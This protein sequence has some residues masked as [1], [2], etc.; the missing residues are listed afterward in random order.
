MLNLENGLLNE[1]P[2]EAIDGL[3]AVVPPGI[4]RAEFLEVS[5]G[6]WAK[7]PVFV[8]NL[9]PGADVIS[10]Q[11]SVH[12]DPVVLRADT[13]MFSTGSVVDNLWRIVANEISPGSLNVALAGPTPILGN[14]V[15]VDLHF[16]VVG[17]PGDSTVL[18]LENGLLN[19]D[20]VETV[21]GLVKV[22]A[23]VVLV[24]PDNIE[25]NEGEMELV[26]V[27]LEGNPGG[28]IFSAEMGIAYNPAVVRA[29][30]VTLAG[31][32]V[33]DSPSL[34]FNVEN[35]VINIG[36]ASA[37]PI[38]GDGPLVFIKF[39]AVGSDGD[40]TDVFIR[41]TR[42]GR[43]P[44][45][46]EG[47]IPA[48]R[49]G[50]IRIIEPSVPSLALSDT[51]LG[52]GS[53]RIDSSSQRTL[54]IINERGTD[55][56]VDSLFV[57]NTGEFTIIEPAIEPAPLDTILA[58]DSL[59]VTI[60]FKPWFTGL[61]EDTLHILS[62]D[63]VHPDTTVLLK[64][65]TQPPASI[66]DI[67]VC[68][69]TATGATIT[70][71]TDRPATLTDSVRVLNP[72]IS[73]NV[74]FT[75][76]RIGFNTHLVGLS[77]L[78]PDVTGYLFE[79]ISEGA[80]S[81]GEFDTP[82]EG[83]PG[84]PQNATVK[85]LNEDGTDAVGVLV[86]AT[87]TDLLSSIVSLPICG[88]TGPTGGATLPLDLV[89]GVHPNPLVGLVKM[90][91]GTGSGTF[92]TVVLEAKD[93]KGNSASSASLA[94]GTM[95]LNVDIATLQLSPPN[96]PI[97]NASP[98]SLNFG[99]VQV[100]SSNRDTVTLKSVGGDTLD[101]SGLSGIDPPFSIVSSVT[102]PDTLPP[103]SS[104]NVVVEFSATTAGAFLDTLIV[105]SNDTVNPILNIPLSG[106]S[107][108][109][110]VINEVLFNPAGTL[111]ANRNGTTVEVEDEFIEI[112]NV[113]TNPVDITGWTLSDTSAASAFA[114]PGG[115]SIAPG[116]F[117]VL[118]GDTT[119]ATGF[120]GQ[121]FSDPDGLIGNGLGGPE[122]VV[123]KTGG[124]D[125]VD[126]VFS[127]S[128][129][130]GKSLVRIP[131]GTGAFA[132]HDSPN[133]IQKASPGEARV[134][135]SSIATQP[136]SVEIAAGLTAQLS[137]K[138]ISLADTTD[139]TG[140][141]TWSSD[142]QSIAAVNDSG[143]VTANQEGTTFV[144]AD[145]FGLV[146][147]TTVIVTAPLLANI[148]VF[149]IGKDSI[150]VGEQKQFQVERTFTD[151]SRDTVMAAPGLM[152]MSAEDT[153]ATVDTTGLA[154]GVGPGM[155]YIKGMQ[156]ALVDS[157]LVSVFQRGDVNASFSL[158]GLDVVRIVNIIVRIPPAPNA[159]EL[160]AGEFRIGGGIGIF[161]AVGA[162]LEIIGIPLK[163]LPPL[164]VLPPEVSLLGA[165]LEDGQ[166]LFPVSL[167]N[168]SPTY[169][170]QM[171]IKYDPSSMSLSD[172]MLTD[173]SRNMGLPTTR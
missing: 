127:P 50:K 90:N 105:T 151:G 85:V 157:A 24:I 26:P 53:V 92:L 134:E 83:T 48:V 97:I 56:I 154:T 128:P 42:G 70:W 100:A 158:E 13:S 147:T 44:E 68:N 12:Y 133:A 46:N 10:A 106:S 37:N 162:V 140:L 28:F 4:L 36:L 30:S 148:N 136:N 65:E 40:S 116:E 29:D 161:D 159:F 7:V 41:G 23:P 52:F 89:A 6:E 5:P 64:G 132:D 79:I 150:F 51:L 164:A 16:E 117:I 115:T 66:S 61:R 62:N 81:V 8:D 166:A 19:E 144:T 156:N 76:S 57:G 146:D 135:L 101:I 114:F 109:Q 118:F 72:S 167:D 18:D 80:T 94:S 82:P 152:W 113:G 172:V 43:L 58:G 111:D 75:A 22:V 173:R 171:R 34:A 121:I 130:I 120:A 155:T 63:P 112:Y 59:R 103:G 168:S 149:E 98:A 73:L 84:L 141:V 1:T 93:G 87:V 27:I 153:V 35:G 31:T 88:L 17:A 122:G 104:T 119:G 2:V 110:V 102:L 9:F 49:N 39:T 125:T 77:G 3:L 107:S 20:S 60:E 15:L 137:A 96:I 38:N 139:I 54:Y 74:V 99:L 33:T 11:F 55:L 86:S 67:Q 126:S 95:D 69:L 169:G 78:I 131:E 45:L 165:S 71:L 25:I 163:T 124:G 138:G 21:D 142:N 145:I 143:K 123:L 47:I 32:I 129:P 170:V 108:F 14:G 160:L 91:F